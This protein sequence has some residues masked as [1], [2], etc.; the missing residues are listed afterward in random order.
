MPSSV[1]FVFQEHLKLHPPWLQRP[2]ILELTLFLHTTPIF[3]AVA[4]LIMCV[5]KCSTGQKM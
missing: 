1:T 3:D 5:I 4:I 2:A